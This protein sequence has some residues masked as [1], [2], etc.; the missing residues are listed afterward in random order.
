MSVWQ[1]GG[2]VARAGEAAAVLTSCQWTAGLLRFA[3]MPQQISSH[4]LRDLEDTKQTKS[5]EHTMH[6]TTCVSFGDQKLSKVV[7]VER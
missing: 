4:S 7:V 6:T 5:Y 1:E 2:H 3:E